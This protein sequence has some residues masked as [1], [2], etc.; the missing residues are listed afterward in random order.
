MKNKVFNTILNVNSIF[1][2]LSCLLAPI[3]LGALVSWLLTKNQ[4]VGPWIYV[5]L[6]T[7]GVFI[8]LISMITF[9][10]KCAETEK[11]LKAAAEKEAET[12]DHH[13]D[14]RR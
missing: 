2:A 8:G 4:L 11:A 7:A 10:L 6:I 12:A 13:D 14:D 3:A 5:V 9:L 1:Q